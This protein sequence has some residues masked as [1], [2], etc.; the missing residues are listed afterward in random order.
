MEKE[1]ACSGLRYASATASKVKT[2]LKGGTIFGGRSEEI[3][4]RF[5]DK[6]R[7]VA[8]LFETEVKGMKMLE[9]TIEYLFNRSS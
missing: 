5:G 6:V 1:E 9:R 8:P 2:N 4:K 7:A 3:W